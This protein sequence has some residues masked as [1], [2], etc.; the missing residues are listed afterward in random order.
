MAILDPNERATRAIALALNSVSP[1]LVKITKNDPNDSSSDG[2]RFTPEDL[3]DGTFEDVGLTDALRIN[4]FK[5]AL[6]DVLPEIADK[7]PADLATLQPGARIA[8]VFDVIKGELRG[9]QV[10]AKGGAKLAAKKSSTASKGS[11]KS[12]KG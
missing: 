12:N 9:L 6:R 7:I 10:A 5:V 1:Q 8:D 2:F 4:G 3:F 11:K